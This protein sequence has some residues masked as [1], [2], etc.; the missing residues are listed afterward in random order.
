MPFNACRI[1]KVFEINTKNIT[2]MTGKLGDPANIDVAFP[3]PASAFESSVKPVPVANNEPVQPLVNNYSAAP[4]NK[5]G[6]RPLEESS[7][8]A[9][10]PPMK[11]ATPVKK[12]A[13]SGMMT[14][15]TGPVL[16][17]IS[18]LSP[19]TEA[20]TIRARCTQKSDIKAWT[21]AK[22]EGKLFS[23][24]FIDGSGEI[25]VTG[26]NE[27]CD[28]F[29]EQLHV[30]NIYKLSASAVKPAK[31]AFNTT[32]NDYEIHLGPHSE[33]ELC[34][35]E[36][37]KDQSLPQAHYSFVSIKSLRDVERDA[38]VDICAIVKEAAEPS[39]II[40]K[41]KQQPLTKRE[42]LLVDESLHSI[43]C[44]L[45]G[46][47]AESYDITLQAPVIIIKSAKVSDYAGT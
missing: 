5:A 25:R 14:S 33:L 16:M 20:W 21:N 38:L 31:K 2:K 42:L 40:T 26:F 23:A 3:P 35:G 44:T 34:M 29:Y 17:P 32:R 11:K 24:T 19:Y 28:Q 27:Q 1:L 45:W 13:A 46:H 9:V 18:A 41:T 30:G 10:P 8:S 4:Q 39:T 36:E 15:S 6:A 37:A 7:A 22:G 12:T 43:R 47:Q